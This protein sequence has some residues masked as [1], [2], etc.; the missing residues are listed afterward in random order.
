MQRLVRLSTDLSS[1]FTV[2]R[3]A[4]VIVSEAFEAIGPDNGALWLMDPT[5]T[6]L[7][8]VRARG[9]TL[10]QERRFANFALEDQNPLSYAV[11]RNEMC[12]FETWEDYAARFPASETTVRGLSRPP[13]M[14]FACLPL[15]VDGQTIG[16]LSFTFMRARRF[17]PDERTFMGLLAQQ[18]ARGIERAQLY[19]RAM[20][21]VRMRDDFLLVAGHELRTPLASLLLQSELL[22]RVTDETPATVVRD[23]GVLVMRS[24]RRLIGLVEELLDTSRLT[25]GRLQLRREL[26]DVTALV[27]EVVART[28]SGGTRGTTNVSVR[29]VGPV[30]G[31]WDRAR[32]EQ[33]VTN[34]LTNAVKYGRGSPVEIEV[35]RSEE[36]ALVTVRDRGIGIGDADQVRI[37]E[38]FERAVSSQQYGGLG[39]GL[40]ITREIVEAHGGRISVASAPGEGATFQ[41]MLPFKASED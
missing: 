34:L 31:S 25:T 8:M 38:R 3:V 26:V 5:R 4:D 32:V 37:F 39:L 6:R 12:W 19:D 10:E 35:G 16:G 22:L 15:R 2:S 1:A 41:V 40:W 23:R 27:E 24:V 33:V 30:E 21:A 11:R 13:D 9:Y 17:H 29:A 28:T 20:D 18:C 36:G 14:S 7:Q